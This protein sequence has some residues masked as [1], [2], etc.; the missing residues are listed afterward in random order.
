LW[1]LSGGDG[2]P[3]QRIE[4]GGYLFEDAAGLLYFQVSEIATGDNACQMLNSQAF[5]PQGH[6]TVASVH[7]HPFRHRESVAVCYPAQTANRSY[8]AR[9][10][11][12]FSYHRLPNGTVTGDL[13]RLQDDAET[14]GSSFRGAFI[15]DR[16]RIAFAPVGATIHNIRTIGRSYAREQQSGCEIA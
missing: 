11:F 14:F 5:P 4:R 13:K 12:G 1:T 9:E 7:I 6:V 3:N 15:M 10:R 8:E 16:D 2:P